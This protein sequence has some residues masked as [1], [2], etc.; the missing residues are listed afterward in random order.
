MALVLFNVER[1]E[2][3]LTISCVPVHNDGKSDK[4]LSSQSVCASS[5][6]VILRKR[7]GLES[8]RKKARTGVTGVKGRGGRR[9]IGRVGWEREKR[10]S[11]RKGRSAMNR[12]RGLCWRHVNEDFRLDQEHNYSD[13]TA[14]IQLD[15]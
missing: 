15:V 1:A 5:V 12:R 8:G 11:G 2:C 4:K 6:T 10:R 9:K 13:F 7:P 14:L 3:V